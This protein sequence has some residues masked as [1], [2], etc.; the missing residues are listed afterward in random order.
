M[1]LNAIT[2]GRV[3]ETVG[4][5]ENLRYRAQIWWNRLKLR[6]LPD[7]HHSRG[8]AWIEWHM[9]RLERCYAILQRERQLN[10]EGGDH[11]YIYNLHPRK[12]LNTKYASKSTLSDEERD[13]ELRVLRAE[14]RKLQ[15]EMTTSDRP[16][17]TLTWMY[18]MG[19]CCARECGCC[20]K[21]LHEYVLHKYG[22]DKEHTK[23]PRKVYGHCTSE[24]ACCVITHEFY[25]PH[26]H[27]PTPMFVAQGGAS[28]QRLALEPAKLEES[29]GV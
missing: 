2:K 29:E 24:C 12:S 20:E 14:F 8:R 11:I 4:Q 15:K 25:E 26:E 27:L 7:G 13:Q 28:G 5:T 16:D 22:L 10:Q 23:R 21:L 19:G 1:T 17:D 3:L 9:S 6:L 18:R